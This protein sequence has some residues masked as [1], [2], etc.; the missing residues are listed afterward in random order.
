MKQELLNI[1]N[2]LINA[3]KDG[4]NIETLQTNYAL[5]WSELYDLIAPCLRHHLNDVKS[6]EI[7]Q[8][9]A[10]YRQGVSTTKIGI[11]LNIHHK[12]VSEILK[13]NDISI[14]QSKSI[15][16]YT[17]NENY[18]DNID[19]PNKAYIL[20]LLFADGYNN[21]HKGEIRL[22]LQE[23]DKDILEKIRSE[24]NYNKPLSFRKCDD[25][26]AS[27]GFISVNMYTLDIYNIHMSK[28]LS[29]L[30][31]VQNKS[32]ILN[33]PTFLDEKLYS[34]FIRGYFDGDGSYC[35]RIAPKYGDRDLITFTSTEQFCQ[36]I[37][38]I[39]NKYSLATGGGI[40]DAS[41]HNGVT[42]VLSFSGKRQVTHLLNWL[43]QDA[44]LYMQRKRVLYDNF[45]NQNYSQ[46]A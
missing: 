6:D 1:R 21:E 28:A 8:I 24:L 17:I 29:N 4:A 44:E 41:C 11:K 34:H 5:K 38:S 15:R 22:S 3:Y 42:K 45:C 26:V 16:K 9:C 30:N 37:K 46:S 12:I 23:K 35:H 7:A 25:I 40:Y 36:T 20:G 27:N 39:I 18:F 2:D 32:L 33:F 14:S 13:R 19:T 31:M 43:Y 10:L